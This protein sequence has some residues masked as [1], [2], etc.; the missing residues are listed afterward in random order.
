MDSVCTGIVPSGVMCTVCIPLACDKY[1]GLFGLNQKPELVRV[2]SGFQSMVIASLGGI[3]V[4]GPDGP[5]TNGV[6]V[7]AKS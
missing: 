5:H 7:W 4:F 1:Y 2:Q 6:F 3:E